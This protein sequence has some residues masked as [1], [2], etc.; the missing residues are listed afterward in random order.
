MVNG[1][2]QL[3][4]G[5]LEG[6]FTGFSEFE[7]RPNESA[8]V[9]MKRLK[10]LMEKVYEMD[11]PETRQRKLRELKRNY[12]TALVRQFH[13]SYGK[14]EDDLAAWHKLLRHCGIEK[15]PKTS[16]ACK[17]VCTDHCITPVL[18]VSLDC[19]KQVY[20]P[21]WSRGCSRRPHA[22]NQ[23]LCHRERIE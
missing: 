16:A 22:D 20:Q 21:N 14:D 6:F 10:V 8:S 15:L 13:L 5:P 18:N 11:E 9:Q 12:D 7:Y 2:N 19:E 1:A 17:R 3:P 23:T 4:V